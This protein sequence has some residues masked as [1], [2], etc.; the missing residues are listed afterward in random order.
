MQVWETPQCHNLKGP[1]NFLGFYLLEFHQDFTK[2][3]Q[4]KF[5]FGSGK[6]EGKNSNFEIDKGLLSD[7]ALLFKG[8]ALQELYF[9]YVEEKFLNPSYFW[10]CC[11]TQEGEQSLELLKKSKS[12][13]IWP[14]RSYN[15]IR[16]ENAPSP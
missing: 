9:S 2:M 6:R 3:N 16:L 8:K 14:L 5:S 12:R 1:Q 10:T 13:D 11:L 7:K 4:E 15:L